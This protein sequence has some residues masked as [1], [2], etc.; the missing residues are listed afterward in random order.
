MSSFCEHAVL[1]NPHYYQIA[2]KFISNKLKKQKLNRSL[3]IGRKREK[4]YRSLSKKEFLISP[5]PHLRNNYL[6]TLSAYDAL[7]FIEAKVQDFYLKIIKLFYSFGDDLNFYNYY[8]FL[9][10]FQDYYQIYEDH[11]KEAS[12]HISSQ[13]TA[14]YKLLE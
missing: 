7:E 14:K 11:K 3:Q 1:N 4:S 6:I 12:N 10:I 13:C 9:K 2:H 5:P 8:V